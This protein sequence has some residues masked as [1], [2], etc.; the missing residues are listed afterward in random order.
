MMVLQPPCRSAFYE[1]AIAAG[2]RLIHLLPGSTRCPAGTWEDHVLATPEEAVALLED[3]ENVGVLLAGKNGIHPNPLGLW[4]LRIQSEQA[5]DQFKDAP[6][7][8][9]LSWGDP[10][11]CLLLARLPN[12]DTPRKGRVVK[13]Q[14]EAKLAGILPAPGSI[15]PEGGVVEVSI[16]AAGSQDWQP[17]TG[18]LIAWEALPV[19]DPT[20][21]MPS[22]VVLLPLDEH[23]A[24]QAAT[25]VP[26]EWIFFDMNIPPD[27]N[28][29]GCTSARGNQGR[30][31][32]RAEGFIRNRIRHGVVSRAGDGG[33]RTLLSIAI[34]L[35]RY[36]CLPDEV[37]LELLTKPVHGT[38]VAWNDL[39][40]DA[41]T[42]CRMPWTMEELKAA[43]AAAHEYLP[44][45]GVAEYLR[46]QSVMEGI[47]RLKAFL[48]L[49]SLLPPPQRDAPST[50]AQ[51]LYTTFLEMYS[52]DKK[53]VSYRRFSLAIQSGI[54]TGYLPLRGIRRTKKKLRYYQGVSAELIDFALE[55]AALRLDQVA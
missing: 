42:H 10:H 37:V 20:T 48:K 18:T 35:V 26:P 32:I 15:H 19:V 22:T 3:G 46:F 45:F 12:P 54:A 9:K 6:F 17:W 29:Q 40:V 21:F 14:H 49:L 27:W 39:C 11:K 52:V 28:R 23:R 1:S 33:R 30:R 13:D 8:L 7:T 41:E 51:D 55:E 4:A 5:L 44:P 24:A 47:E 34:H 31:K 50:K 2:F 36:L 43:I 53:D 38:A 25:R 16:R